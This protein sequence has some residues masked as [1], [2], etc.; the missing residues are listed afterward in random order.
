M[1]YSQMTFLKCSVSF[2]CGNTFFFTYFAGL[3]ASNVRPRQE[4]KVRFNPL[5]FR[6]GKLR[7]QVRYNRASLGVSHYDFA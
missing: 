6:D 4:L 2:P 7:L 3:V 1:D 5:I